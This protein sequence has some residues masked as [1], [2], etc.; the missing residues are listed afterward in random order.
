LSIAN[1]LA[2]VT[3]V[4]EHGSDSGISPDGIGII[5]FSA[6]GTVSAGVA[7]NYAQDGRPAFA[8]LFHAAGSRFRDS[9]VPVDALPVFVAAATDDDLGLTP[10]SFVWLDNG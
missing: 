6:G 5:G 8:A 2:A 3:Y 7:F 1:G 10:D 4:R 9:P